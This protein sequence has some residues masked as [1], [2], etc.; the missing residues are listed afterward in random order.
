MTDEELARKL[1][2]DL[3]DNISANEL[4]YSRICALVSKVIM[5]LIKEAR[6]VSGE[7]PVLKKNGRLSKTISGEYE[8]LLEE[9]GGRE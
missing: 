8:K 1:R 3:G 9:S 5:P 2:E 4:S 6:K 7:P